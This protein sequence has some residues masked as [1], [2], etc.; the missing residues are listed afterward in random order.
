MDKTKL[1]EEMLV[2]YAFLKNLHDNNELQNR[3]TLASA[4]HGA[5]KILLEILHCIT[6]GLI[7]LKRNRFVL[8][9]K[10]NKLPLIRRTLQ[11]T[12]DFESFLE[13]PREKWITFLFQLL[14]LYPYLLHRLFHH[15]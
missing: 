9:K 3:T 8:L 15:D 13:L 6:N 2:N 11:G 7:P 12:S 14:K 10:S 1:R 5:L 4:D